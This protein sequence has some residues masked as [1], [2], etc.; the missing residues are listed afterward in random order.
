M[1]YNVNSST[2]SIYVHWP[3]CPYK[4]HYCPFVALAS[5]DQFMEQYH[6]ALVKEINAF[7]SWYDEKIPLNT[8]Y[9]GGGTPSTY[10]DNLLLDMS[11]ILNHIFK[12]NNNTEFTLEVN[13]G[14]VRVEQFQIWQT[15]GINR[16]SIGVQSLNDKVL[17]SLNRHQSAK[18]VYFL[19]DK[20]QHYFENM[21]IDVILGLPDISQE[22]WKEQ[23]RT[24]V[25]WPI[26]HISMY[27]LTIHEDTPLYFKVHTKKVV[28]P[29][30]DTMLKLYYW[31]RDFLIEHGF[32]HYEISSFARPGYQSRHNTAYWERVPYKAFGL[33]ACSFD[34]S[35][36]FQNEKNIMKYIQKV[37]NNDATTVFSEQ[38]TQRQIHLEKVMLGLRRS[39]GV[40]WEILLENLSQA[41][42][43]LVIKKVDEFEKQNLIVQKNGVLMLTASGLA[44]ENEIIVQ[45]CA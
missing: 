6:N 18:D 39:K 21:S 29:H 33:G 8:V 7:G 9:F 37:E 43:D 42:I 27:F 12:F 19:L 11:G 22:E 34:G 26:K 25:T 30:D 32:E 41:E 24:V 2:H 40:A 31:S 4:C 10:P 15:V 1:Q 13:P 38:L 36:R 35:V 5:Q 44:V 14:T 16:L 28:L 3:F 45:L 20:A 17:K 23:L